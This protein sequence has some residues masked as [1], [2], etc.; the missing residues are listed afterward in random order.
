MSILGHQGENKCM[1]EEGACGDQL[2]DSHLAKF[3]EQCDNNDMGCLVI[4]LAEHQEH[5]GVG[6]ALALNSSS[7][8][9][10]VHAPTLNT[11]T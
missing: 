4:I 1:A 9:L 10:L 11:V 5:Q 3:G 2:E 6:V 7:W 8:R